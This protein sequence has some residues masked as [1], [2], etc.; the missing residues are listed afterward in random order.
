MAVWSKIST[1]QLEYSRIDA[2]FYHPQYLR[3][4]NAW[5]S[6][7]E[8]IKV[9][10]LRS[11]I[12]YPVRTGRTPRSRNY[13]QG[14][15]IVPFIKTDDVR[16][17]YINFENPSYL[18]CQVL[19]ARDYIPG[20]SV[21]VTIIGATPDIVGRAAIV[22]KLDHE[23]VT[24]QNIAVISTSENCDPYYLTA[25]LQTPMGRDQLWRHA[26]RTEQVNLNCREVER[27]L[28]P[29]PSSDVQYKIGN[30]LRESF[31]R[32]DQSRVL[33]SQAEQLLETELGL[34][35]LNLQKP[36]GYTAR[37]S[38][39]VS[40]N[41]IDADFYQIPFRQIH[42][43][44]DKFKTERLCQL[45]QLKKG[46]EVGSKAYSDSGHLFLRVGN[47]KEKQIEVNTSDKFISDTLF[48][49]L[50]AYQPQKGELLLT[51]DGSP[52]I[53]YVVD[54]EIDG[55]VSG[56]ILRL[57]LSNE[58]IPAEYLALVIN[59]K[60]C[61][62]QVEQ[63]C[64]GALILHWKPSSVRNLRIPLLHDDIMCEIA[65]LVIASKQAKLES[66]RLLDKAKTR[67]EQMI[68]EAVQHE[69]LA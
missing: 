44:L 31:A 61:R 28:V 11:L 13:K 33:Y 15:Q 10:K 21:V 63:D 26:R 46:I 40:N 43:H 58:S 38:E 54:Q 29:L 62:M 66:E 52:G 36:V 18:P 2:D 45:A 65:N 47:V 68:E 42:Q 32:T 3:E 57:L 69:T 9:T 59:S 25:F 55:I 39:I 16:E 27:I 64:S 1:S 48:Q 51:K 6:I 19:R 37:F 20:D 23:C 7:S 24:N 4:L 60:V 30:M 12:C 22:R 67:V 53:C 14:E 49:N 41:R 5:H 35:Q 34:D 56:G 17:G 8:K 50:I